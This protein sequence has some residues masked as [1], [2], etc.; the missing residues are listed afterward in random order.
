M[1]P[2]VPRQLPRESAA[3]NSRAVAGVI[4]TAEFVMTLPINCWTSAARATSAAMKRAS[5]A[6]TS[7]SHRIFTTFSDRVGNDNFR[8]SRANARALARPIPIQHR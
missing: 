8:A 4:K 2:I 6:A 3:Y 7:I 1:R 5:P